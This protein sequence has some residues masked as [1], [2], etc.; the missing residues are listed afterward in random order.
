MPLILYHT[1][2]CPP[3]FPQAR[4]IRARQKIAKKYR[5]PIVRVGRATLIDEAAADARLVELA[6]YQEPPAGRRGRPRER[7]Q[8]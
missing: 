2:Y 8:S 4:T 7:E 1:E 5:L 6:L 3:R